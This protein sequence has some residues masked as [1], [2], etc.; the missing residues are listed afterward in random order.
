MAMASSA[1]FSCFA[2]LLFMR[3]RDQMYFFPTEDITS[4]PSDAGIPF[5]DI[6]LRGPHYMVNVWLVTRDN[7]R[8][9][10]IFSHG[11]A[12]NM[13]HRLPVLQFLYENLTDHNLVLYDYPG[14]GKSRSQKR[15]N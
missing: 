3:K 15:P 13:S 8:H 4:T 9:T 11:N 2:S 7:A 12:G 6:L 1:L 14:F 5:K 10:L